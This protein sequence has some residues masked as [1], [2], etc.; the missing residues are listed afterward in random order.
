MTIFSIIFLFEAG[1]TCFILISVRFAAVLR[2]IK[3][4]KIQDG[5]QDAGHVVK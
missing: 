1:N 4:L 3:F 2:E 5:G